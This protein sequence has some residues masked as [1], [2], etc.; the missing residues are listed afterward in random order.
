MGGWQRL[1]VAMDRPAAESL[2]EGQTFWS[3]L[4][5]VDGKERKARPQNP[6][7]KM[8]CRSGSEP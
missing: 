6:C 4:S 5:M 2:I 3:A 7:T 8:R 1:L